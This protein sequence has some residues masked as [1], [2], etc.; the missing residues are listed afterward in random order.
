MSLTLNAA[1]A[2][3]PPA[4]A[5]GASQ[6]HFDVLEYRVLGNTVLATI[7]IEKLLYPLLGTDKSLNDVE[8]ARTALEE[9]Y[10]SKGF[11]TVFVDIPPQEVNDGVVRLHVT[12]GRIESTHI[13]G[14]RYF[15]ERGVLVALPASTPGTVPNLPALQ[16]QLAAVN[17]QSSDRVVVPI[18]R[19]GSTPGTVDLAF[20]VDDHLPL[21]G[22]LEFN[23]QNTIDTRPLR[24]I[25]QL[26]Y[27]DLFGRLDTISL[28]YQMAP[29][30]ADQVSVFAANY[31][32]HP[33]AYGL[34][35]SLLL[36]D[37]NSNVATVGT[38]G[39]LGQGEIIGARLALPFNAGSTDA[40]SLTLGLDHKHFRN[41][42][43]VDATTA[44]NTPITYVNLSLSYAGVWR[45]DAR[46]IT[47]NVASDFGPR[48]IANNS[49]A[50]ANDRFE[51]RANYFYVRADS[52]INLRL[53]GAFRLTLRAAGQGAAEPTITNENYSIAGADGVRGYL[54]SEELGDSAIKGTVQLQSPEW[55]WHE[56][57]L[58]DLFSFYDAGRT[59][60]LDA[61]PDQPTHAVLRSWGIGADLLPGQRLTGSFTWAHP[62]LA[63]TATRAGESRYLF[64]LRGSF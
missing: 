43:N 32:S 15:P 11:G 26:S 35:P 24:A 16:Q 53:P 59:E 56:R 30:E 5:A 40:Q 60:V 51:G 8:L 57:A 36:I 14:A 23:D 12:E 46:I 47:L 27:G 54:E 42:I 19:Q 3:A 7:D 18:I 2:A 48:G 25:G 21:H 50:F 20:K 55:R 29:Q 9:L 37:S 44:L 17:G 63:A 22:S 28:Q 10:H 39:I 45:T 34:T 41:T 61:L 49:N 1:L 58:G 38:L 62:L 52:A 13:D 4:A 64:V 31:A 33:L 6:Q